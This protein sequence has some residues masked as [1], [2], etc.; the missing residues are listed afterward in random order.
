MY[1]ELKSFFG[2]IDLNGIFE[3]FF[4][5]FLG[6]TF[7]LIFFTLS[8]RKLVRLSIEIE[9]RGIKKMITSP[10][11]P[12]RLTVAAAASAQDESLGRYG[13]TNQ[14]SPLFRYARAVVPDSNI[15][16]DR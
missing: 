14:V 16:R 5:I 11:P 6:E 12:R 8:T 15:F 2:C 9:G 7:F 1:V 10:P 3:G 13:Q 4:V